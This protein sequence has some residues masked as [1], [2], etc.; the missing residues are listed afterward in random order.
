MTDLEDGS[1][2]LLGSSEATSNQTFSIH[3]HWAHT[4]FLEESI[5]FT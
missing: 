1:K 3:R 2:V 4:A 5:S